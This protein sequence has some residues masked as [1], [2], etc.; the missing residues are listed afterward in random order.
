MASVEKAVQLAV[1]IANDN[2]HGYSQDNRGGNPDFDCSSLVSKVFHDA[3][4]N[5]K[6]GSTTKNLYEQFIKCGFKD[7][8]GQKR[9]RGDVLLK[10]GHHIVICVDDKNIVH[11]SINELGK[12]TGGKK[13]DQTGREICVRS[14]YT[15][16]GGWDYQLRYEEP[17]KEK[18]EITNGNQK[19]ETF[20]FPKYIVGKT[21]TLAKQRHIYSAADTKSKKLA[22]NQF[23]A[24][25]KLQD[26]NKDAILDKGAKVTCKE[27]KIV[28]NRLWMR[29]PSGWIVAYNVN[30]NVKAVK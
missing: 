10:V 11:A 4:F 2:S 23:T 16:R 14:Y 29:I 13:G 12:T 8:S 20:D 22:Y 30:N 6:L 18:K 27:T 7:V 24:S 25:A 21:Y 28:D 26:K 5:I 1:S 15:Y 19:N 17:K 3:G 9:K